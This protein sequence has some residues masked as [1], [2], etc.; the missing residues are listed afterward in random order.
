MGLK[1]AH[2]TEGLV[3]PAVP[4]TEPIFERSP[5]ALPIASRLA[6]TSVVGQFLY[7]FVGHMYDG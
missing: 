3:R 5:V 6:N 4:T 7:P 1:L 2:H